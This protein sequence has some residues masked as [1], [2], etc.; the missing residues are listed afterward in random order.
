LEGRINKA[1]G[2]EGA[3]GWEGGLYEKAA[4]MKYPYLSTMFLMLGLGWAS[5]TFGVFA[6][7]TRT[8]AKG[9]ELAILVTGLVLYTIFVESMFGLFLRKKWREIKGSK[10]GL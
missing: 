8:G 6:I 10:T 5:S 2:V 4:H 1:L 7:A 9:R 3:M